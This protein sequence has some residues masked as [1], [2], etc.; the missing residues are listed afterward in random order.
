MALK[1]L[2]GHMIYTETT[3][4]LERD[5]V[6]LPTDIEARNKLIESTAATMGIEATRR[7]MS[8]A[9]EELARRAAARETNVLLE[10]LLRAIGEGGDDDVAAHV[11]QRSSLRG[12]LFGVQV[13]QAEMYRALVKMANK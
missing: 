13:R 2:M 11:D 1:M 9:K 8:Q 3:A 4:K 10:R 7:V 6:T 5:G 12:Q